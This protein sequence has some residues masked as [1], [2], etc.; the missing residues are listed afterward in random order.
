M[1]T[2]SEK[3]QDVF[4]FSSSSQ[5]AEETEGGAAAAVAMMKSLLGSLIVQV[6]QV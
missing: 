4:W 6:S 3:T 1:N 2:K 5:N